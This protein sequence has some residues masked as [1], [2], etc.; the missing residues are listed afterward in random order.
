MLSVKHK[1]NF[2]S[3]FQPGEIESNFN[4]AKL[5][6]KVCLYKGSIRE[7]EFL[8]Y[9]SIYRKKACYFLMWI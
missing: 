3:A 8:F 1:K 2:I 7:N 6:I 4:R 5:G 9:N